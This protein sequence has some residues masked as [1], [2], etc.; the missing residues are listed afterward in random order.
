MLHESS[1]NINLSQQENNLERHLDVLERRLGTLQEQVE[2]LQRLSSLG[3]VSAMLAHEFNNLLTPVISYSQYALKTN[4][5]DLLRTAA[6][7]THKNASRMATLCQKVLGMV[8]DDQM[9]FVETPIRPL[10]MDAVECLG[11]DLEKDDI[12]LNIE[13][14]EDLTARANAGNLQ[15]VLFNLVI[16]ARQAMIERPGRLTIAATHTDN[17]TD[18]S[19]NTGTGTGNSNGKVS[20]HV[21]DNGIGIK[22]ENLSRVFEPFFST[23]K[24]ASK[25][26][27]R[28]IGLGLHICKRLMEEQDGTISINSTPSQGT[29]VTLTLPAP[30]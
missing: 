2:Q 9:G 20:I 10:V 14:P 21:T 13:I 18:T 6:E 17:D 29:T 26:E 28:G 30:Q 22:P 5:P 23:K 12:T 3:T 1:D 25:T 27:R 15:Q 4:D 11:R 24:H 19:T 7:K 16:N 8:T